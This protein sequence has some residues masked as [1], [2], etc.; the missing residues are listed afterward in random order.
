MGR[1]TYIAMFKRKLLHH[2]LCALFVIPAFAQEKYNNPVCGS[3]FPDPTVLRASDGT[4]YAYATGCKCKKSSDLVNWS[5]VSGVISRPTWNDSIKPDGTKDSYSLWAADVNYVDG[6]YICYYAS[7]LWGNGTRTGIGVAMGDTPTKF[8]DKGKLFRSTEI[9]VKNSIDP[10]YV[11]EFDKKYLVWGSFNDICIVELT[12]DALAVKNFHPINNP[13]SDG[14]WKRHTGVTK[15]AGGAFEGA[16]IYKRGKYYYLFCSVGSCCEGGNSTYRTVVGRATKLTGPYVNKQGGQMLSNNYT[17]VISGDSRW[18]GPGHNSEIITDDEGQTW[19]LYHSYDKN[20]SYNGRLMLLDK[21]TW[22]NDWP[23]I[24]DGHPSSGEMDAPIFYTGDGANITYKFQNMDLMKSGWKYWILTASENCETGSGNGTAFMPLGYAK[25]AGNFD[26]QQTI[27]GVNNGVYELTLENFS[28]LGGVDLYVNNAL[29]PAINGLTS[30]ATLPTSESVISNNF[31]NN[32]FTQKV[33]GLVTNGELTIGACTRDSLAP[34]ERFYMGNLKVV[35]REKNTDA[36][37]ILMDTYAAMI[38]SMK[39]RGHNYYAGFDANMEV[40]RKQFS[41]SED[42]TEQYNLLVKISETIDSIQINGGGTAMSLKVTNEEGDDVTDI[43]NIIWF[44]AD[45]KEIGTGKK[46]NGI[47]DS[48]EVY[49]SVVLNESLGRVYREVKMQKVMSQYKIDT[50]TCQLEKIGRVMLEGRVSASDI[51]KTTT[52]V[53]VRQ[54]LNGKWEQTYTTQTNEQGVFKVEVYDDETDITI[55]GEG[56]LDAT[57]H[58]EGFGGSGNVGVIPVNLLSGFAIAANITMQKAVATGEAEEVTA[59]TEGLNNIEFTLT[60]ITDN[61]A[62]TDFTVQNG[63]VIIKTGASVGD[64]V[65]LTAKSKQGVF[66]NATTTFTIA[67]GAN[68]LDLQLTELGG[69]DATCAASENG[70]TT[71]FLYNCNGK[72]VAKGSYV[73]EMLS[74]RHL[75]TGNYTLVSMGRS[76]LLGNL[77]SLSDLSSVGLCEGTDYVKTQVEVTDGELTTVNVSE[78]P[79]LDETRFYYTNN[80]TY[81][82]VNK[83]SVTA[84]NYLTLQ[85]HIDFK[86]E[87]ADKADDVTLTI[88]LPEGCQMVEN[89]VIVNRQAVPHTVNGNRVTMA[90]SKEQYEGQVRFCVI[91]TLNQT[92]TVTAMASFDINGQVTQPIGAAQFEAKG[93]SLSVPE[94]VTRT[95]ITVNGITKGHSE[96]SIYD[97]D[98]LI[99]KTSS[100][101]DGSW[102]AEC[103]LFKPY[104]HSFH[105]IYAKITTETGMELTSETRLVE[106]NK[107]DNVPEKVTMLYRSSKI[108][109]DL[110]QGTTS[111]SYYTYV[112]GYGDFTFLANFTRNDSSEIKNVNIKVLNSDGTVRT[113]PATY[114]GKQNKWVAT[115]KYEGSNRLPQNVKV[116]YYYNDTSTIDDTERSN[117]EYIN[118]ENAYSKL[119]SYIED[120]FDINVISDEDDIVQLSILDNKTDMYHS[121]EVELLNPNE[122]IIDEYVYVEDSEN[123]INFYLKEIIDGNRF[124][125]MIIEDDLNTAYRIRF[126]VCTNLVTQKTQKRASLVQV[127]EFSANAFIPYYD[128]CSGVIDYNFWKDKLPK[129]DEDIT[130]ERKKAYRMLMATCPDGKSKLDQAWKSAFL[131]SYKDLC[132]DHSIFMNTGY[133]LLEIWRNEL[134]KQFAFETA[135]L[136]LGKAIRLLP[137][138]PLNR[139]NSRK[140]RYWQYLVSGGKKNR[141]RAKTMLEHSVEQLGNSLKVIFPDGS[142]SEKMSSWEPKEKANIIR[143]FGNLQSEIQKKYQKCGKD[144]DD[145]FDGDNATPHID[146]SG[147]VYEAVTS[148]RLEGVTVTCYQKVQSEDMYGDITEE[149]VVWNAEDYSQRNPLK[150]DE[151]G[152]YRWDVPQGL[153]QVK[154]E[155]E[156]YETTYSDWLPVPPPQ[157]DVNIGMKQST[158]PSVTQMRGYESGITIDLSK[159]MRP[160]TMTT[161][162]ITVTR[163]GSTEK[164][165][166]ELLNAEKAPLGDEIYVSKV[167]FVPNNHFCVSD[168]VV[169]TVRKEVESYCGVKMTADHVETVKIEPEVKSIE[170]DSILTVVYQGEKELRVQILPK[171]A[172]VGKTLHVRT[173]SEMIA[174]LSSNDVMIDQDGFATLVL[175]GELPGGAM[176]DFSVDGT[177]VTAT[178]K[179]KVV[180]SK[181]MVATP[182]ASIAN[183]STVNSGTQL[184][185]TC[186][187][188]GATIYYTLDGSCPCD[189]QTR[190]LYTEPIALPVGTITVNAIAIADGMDDSEVMSCVFN[191]REC[192]NIIFADNMW[193][194]Y[195]SANP[196]YFAEAGGLKAYIAS[197]Y[198][199]SEQEV[200]MTQVKSVPAKT[201]LLLE[202]EAGKTY[203]VPVAETNYIYS[204]LLVGVLKDTE[205]GAGFVLNKEVFEVINEP[206]IVKA[207][208]A[209]LNITA[210][211]VSQLNLRFTDTDGVESVSSSDDTNW[212]TLLG[213]RLNVK[214]NQKGVYINSGRKVLVK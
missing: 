131:E 109:F 207:G 184:T 61:V 132:N 13:Q 151:T 172:S 30:T 96:V 114:D 47:A 103:E 84:G 41:T 45:G 86:P 88:D 161:D 73:G 152:F 169:V 77:T 144:D 159:Y 6:K 197:G 199:P 3:D 138:I 74:L 93:L 115:T 140:G 95:S 69:V 150:T 94:S 71:G 31:L 15:L 214:P 24:N 187:T 5:D 211:N 119:E 190:I 176:L 54:M 65:Q 83:T 179:V 173:S 202:G 192:E 9:G 209:Y 158:P 122:Q 23:L 39:A 70:E 141:D 40:Y 124:E 112:P 89:S 110:R 38:D 111:P 37:H 125:S 29:T 99:G 20:N 177:D 134:I 178:S 1:F 108:D 191:V 128:Y 130:K 17:T 139:T 25:T 118:I 195:C 50:I 117:D 62:I 42:A 8:T 198:S 135:T 100:K 104:N 200:I 87:Y 44:D 157:L 196:L 55:S 168:I 4:F 186:A 12:D 48:T 57:I 189:E 28:T 76:L 60:N 180:I 49:Y 155:K 154:Y 136:G 91:P 160:E 170:V 210:A 51:D 116:E 22:Q 174:S 156:G 175:F 26:V 7:A 212:H 182:T 34:G 78:I 27:T 208:E 205:I 105:D 165:S 143:Q 43:V 46:L 142:I 149:A 123:N 113:L 58:R 52:I 2:F 120:Y 11:E 147:Y 121:I 97:N 201:G 126:D 14:S 21:I 53:N 129:D 90:L 146:P 63:N 98:V 171:D 72:L 106:Y 193:R 194:T 163:N 68:A 162:N 185:L 56:Y 10:C 75:S 137:D 167:K 127:V 107:K 92:Y 153:W 64:E 35:F 164:G 79:Q 102:T 166:I 148:N 19:L 145:D 67:E 36:M 204:N 82:N 133:D 81:F 66:A 85:A 80:N 59:W 188:E 206:H 18:K 213:V 33:Y 16:M 101:A 32:K 181:G 183:G 203:T